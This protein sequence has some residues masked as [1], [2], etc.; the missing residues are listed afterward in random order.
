MIKYKSKEDKKM[1]VKEQILN[2][3]KKA[4]KPVTASEV[5]TIAGLERKT[6]DKAFKELKTEQKIESPIRCKWQPKL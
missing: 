4:G 5:A 1:E 2:A 6:V 3:M